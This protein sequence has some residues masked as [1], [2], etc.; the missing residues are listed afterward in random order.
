MSSID[1]T[2]R[3]EVPD[4][5]MPTLGLDGSWGTAGGMALRESLKRGSVDDVMDLLQSMN[6]KGV[7]LALQEAGFSF[8]PALVGRGRAALFASVQSDLG[9][10]L[11][12]RGDGFDLSRARGLKIAEPLKDAVAARVNISEATHQKSEVF[13]AYFEGDAEAACAVQRVMRSS[14]ISVALMGGAV[15]G[16]R[17]SLLLVSGQALKKRTQGFS[18]E[19]VVGKYKVPLTMAGVHDLH[20]DAAKA[21]AEESVRT[22]LAAW[23]AGEKV[24]DLDA[25]VLDS[26]QRLLHGSVSVESAKLIMT[27]IETGAIG[28]HASHIGDHEFSRL[29]AEQGFNVDAPPI[30]K[31]AETL[32]LEITEP[33]RARGQYFGMVLALDHR[34]ALI[35]ISR[36]NLIELP[37]AELREGLSRPRMGD[38]VRFGYKNGV[39]AAT[40][41]EKIGREGAGR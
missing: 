34:A 2:S 39:L 18:F 19:G 35:K 16:E 17:S 15:P 6:A 3:T 22:G 13:P 20:R 25:W 26:T 12:L 28:R 1:I 21:V 41:I 23:S 31:Q 33:D 14:S 5:L 8:E 40:V 4:H 29:L 30:E 27:S 32:G 38:S 7:S 37:F 36:T 11:D 10:A 24:N 9:A